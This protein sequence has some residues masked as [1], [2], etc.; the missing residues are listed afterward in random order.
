MPAADI[1]SIAPDTTPVD[2]PVDPHR[3]SITIMITMQGS[4]GR[5]VDRLF[6][7]S[8]HT[9]GD[10]GVMARELL[11]AL[12][13]Q[14]RKWARDDVRAGAKPGTAAVRIVASAGHFKTEHQA[15][16]RTSELPGAF[17]AGLVEAVKSEAWD[18]LYGADPRAISG[19]A[20]PGRDD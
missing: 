11:A 10:P 18:A 4:M 6:T 1:D 19:A 16:G 15:G 14:A 2:P 17:A 9:S 7:S 20:P 13:A 8:A 5:P 12:A 3:A